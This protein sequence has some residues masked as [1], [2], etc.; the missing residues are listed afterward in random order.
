MQKNFEAIRIIKTHELKLCADAR[1]VFPLLCPVKEIDW[2]DGWDEICRMIYTKSGIAEEG[3]IF[4]TNNATEGKAIW[5]CSKYDLDKTRIEYIK[6]IIDK[7]LIK[8]TME[9]KDDS[10]NKSSILMTYNVTGLTDEGNKSIKEHMEVGFPGLIQAI[11]E[12]I[13]YYVSNGKMKLHTHD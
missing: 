1:T 3:C 12:G 11:E 2:I 4:E 9:V 10:E 8:L 5:I 13:N 6:H 7:L